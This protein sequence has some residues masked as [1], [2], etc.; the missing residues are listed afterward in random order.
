MDRKKFPELAFLLEKVEGR[1]NKRLATPKD[2]ELLADE[3][4]FASSPKAKISAST[5]RRIW[6]YDSYESNPTISKLDILARYAGYENFRRFTDM[7][8]SDKSF[9]SGFLTTSFVESG[10]L[11]AGE[12]LLLGWN[13]NRL[14]ELEYLGSNRYRVVKNQNSKMREGDEFEAS[15]FIQGFPM[16][17]SHIERDG[18]ETS[19]YVA[20]FQDGLTL[21][22]R[23]KGC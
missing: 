19:M 10:E 20:G 6:G 16:Y 1:F 21:V 7:L 2:F 4:E 18:D 12:H 5:L 11:E 13:P 14:V 23:V 15:S 17:V 3:I 9:T 22:E 8:K